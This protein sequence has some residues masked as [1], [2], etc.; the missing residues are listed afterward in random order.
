MKMRG[1]EGGGVHVSQMTIVLLRTLH[2]IT[3]FL[4]DTKDVR[5][6]AFESINSGF[7]KSV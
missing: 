3:T 7:K 1:E 4:P 5:I 2:K 6:I